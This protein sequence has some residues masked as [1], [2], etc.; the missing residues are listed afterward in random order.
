MKGFFREKGYD[1]SQLFNRAIPGK[2]ILSIST[3]ELRS[4]INKDAITYIRY[5]LGNDT[6][7]GEVDIKLIFDDEQ[8]NFTFDKETVG[9]EKN[10]VYYRIELGNTNYQTKPEF[11]ISN[12]LAPFVELTKH[13]VSLHLFGM[14]RYSYLLPP[15]RGS[16]MG[17]SIDPA[18]KS[19]MY[20][21]FYKIL[22]REV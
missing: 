4:W 5:L 16:L 18:F 20:V 9:I 6:F 1:Y 22:V 17:V 21:E 19:G 2:V 15:S 11:L 12:E 10:E 13:L 3:E 8:L 7:A 14:R